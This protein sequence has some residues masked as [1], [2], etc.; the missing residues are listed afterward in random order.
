[1]SGVEV[2]NF[3]CRLNIAE[4]EAI[5]AAAGDKDDLIIINSY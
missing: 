5:R 1:M 4:G 2:I 3:G